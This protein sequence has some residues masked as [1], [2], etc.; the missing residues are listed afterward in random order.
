M[1]YRAH[2]NRGGRGDGD[3]F[4]RPDRLEGGQN[5]VGIVSYGD[6]LAER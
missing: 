3:K 1:W 5:R 2:K 6:D 4:A